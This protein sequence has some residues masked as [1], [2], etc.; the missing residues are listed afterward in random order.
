MGQKPA[1]TRRRLRRAQTF[2]RT[3]GI[4]ITFRKTRIGTRII[5]V[6]RSAEET[7]S[8]VSIVS[9]VGAACS[10]GLWGRRR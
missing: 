3:L 5:R 1:S 6:S 8:T 9:L 2:L 10:N 7:V 4:E